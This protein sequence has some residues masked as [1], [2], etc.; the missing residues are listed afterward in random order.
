MRTDPI[1]ETQVEERRSSAGLVYLQSHDSAIGTI[2]YDPPNG[3]GDGGSIMSS[4]SDWLTTDPRSHTPVMEART[5]F[6]TP[7]HL[8]TS[9]G[10]SLRG[11]SCGYVDIIPDAH[12]PT[13][14]RAISP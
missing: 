14:P 5:P 10:K 8:P 4:E 7:Y 12:I 6:T 9:E 2:P 3:A 1:S 11:R 13:G